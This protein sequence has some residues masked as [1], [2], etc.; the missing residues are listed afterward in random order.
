M[1][2]LHSLNSSDI[3]W[4]IQIL[5]WCEVE[6]TWAIYMYNYV[7]I[8]SLIS[9]HIECHREGYYVC[10]LSWSK[11]ACMK[12]QVGAD[13]H[14]HVHCTCI[15]RYMYNKYKG[16]R[17]EFWCRHFDISSDLFTSFMNIPQYWCRICVITC[18]CRYM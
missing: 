18:T 1:Y 8:F 3:Q 7:Y 9:G 6:R 4:H 12:Y 15:M 17:E 10:F 11:Y 5:L 14:V 16:L 13:I 2:V